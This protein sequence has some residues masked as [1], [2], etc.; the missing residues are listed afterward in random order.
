MWFWIS[1]LI[2]AFGVLKS[3][4]IWDDEQKFMAGFKDVN[5]AVK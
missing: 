5:F 2:Y 1:D 4:W 3:T